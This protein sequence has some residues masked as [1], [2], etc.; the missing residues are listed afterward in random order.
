MLPRKQLSASAAAS[1]ARVQFAVI[2]NPHV[3]ESPR[4][5]GDVQDVTRAEHKP[6]VFYFRRQLRAAAT[7]ADARNVALVAAEELRHL[8]EW[9]RTVGGI[10]EAIT[11]SAVDYLRFR[12]ASASTEWDAAELGLLACR[13]LERLQAQVYWD[14]G[15]FVPRWVADQSEA[16]EKGWRAN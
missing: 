12:I 7:L 6:G 5:A 13:E 2:E 11:E 8:S 15:K 10:R 4:S 3:I 14:A 1:S 9:A 16:D